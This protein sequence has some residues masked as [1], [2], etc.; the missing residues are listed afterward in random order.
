MNLNATLIFQMIVF[1]VLTWFTVKFVWPPLVKAIDERRQKIADGLAA[2]EQGK[3]DLA[4]A[5]ERVRLIEATAKQ[6]TQARL[7]DAEKQ[8]TSIIEAARAEAEEERARILAQA[9]QDVQAEVQ[10]VREGLREEVA[11]LAVQGAQQIL[12][13][14]VD[15]K[16][17]ADLLNQLKAQL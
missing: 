13:R 4:K 17:H 5:E 1:F 7:G 16:A 8:A 11:A 12:K 9:K 15:V 10:R 3:E 6:E 2:A 14:E